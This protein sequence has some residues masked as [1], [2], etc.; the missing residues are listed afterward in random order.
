MAN[1]VLS[2]E[3]SVAERRRPPASNTLAL[4]HSI[5]PFRTPMSTTQE[6]SVMLT[7]SYASRTRSMAVITV[8]TLLLLDGDSCELLTTNKI[9]L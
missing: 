4:K 1:K 2:K 5:S 7:A 9:I 6:I 8:E 3:T